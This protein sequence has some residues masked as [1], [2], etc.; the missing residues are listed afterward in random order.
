[1]QTNLEI[2]ITVSTGGNILIN[3]GPTNTGLIQPI[4]V[5]R[6]RAMGTWLQ[7]NGDAIY[8]SHPWIYQNDTTTP[9]VWYTSKTLT[10]DRIVVYAIV[11]NYPYDSAGVNLFSLGGKFDNSTTTKLLGYPKPL[12]VSVIKSNFECT[13]C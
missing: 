12:N 2:A 8:E 4:F 11:L 13:I 3:V 6:L 10:S 9:D 1:M 5:E 7:I